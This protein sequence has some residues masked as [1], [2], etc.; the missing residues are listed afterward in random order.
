MRAP[1]Y[2]PDIDGI[3]AIAVVLVI[4]FHAG[5]APVSGGYIGVDVFFVIS[6]YL[7]TKLLLAPAERRLL[8]NLAEFY[9]RR[10]RRIVPALVAVLLVATS[11]AI[12]LLM[13]SDLV[14][15]GRF[16]LSVPFFVSNLEA[17]HETGYF[18]SGAPENP[19]LHLWSISVEEQFYLL[20]P[21]LLLALA[22]RGRRQ[23][24]SLL[25]CAAVISFV[26]CCWGSYAKPSATYYLIPPRAWE[27]LL[28]GLGAVGAIRAP[29]SK[30]SAE[31]ISAVALVAISVAA[32]TYSL[33]TPYPGIYAAV[34]TAST[35]AL[36]VVGATHSTWTHK[37][38]S[39]RPLVA[40][41]LISYSL[42]LWHLPI[43][44]FYRYFYL[45]QF[46]PVE[47]AVVL[48]GT[49]LLSAVTWYV[50]EQP[51]RRR[52]IF[53]SRR[54]VVWSALL[55]NCVIALLGLMFLGTNGLPERFSAQ[56]LAIASG[57][58][59]RDK[60][61]DKCM[62]LPYNE[63][64]AGNLCRYGSIGGARIMVWG[65]S[66]AAALLPAYRVLARRHGA[67]LYFAAESA[68]RPLLHIV[69]IDAPRW[70]QESCVR[71]NDA[72]VKAVQAIDPNVV[73]LSGHWIDSEDALRS[74][75]GAVESMH[76][77]HFM[78]GLEQTIAAID[79]DK[80]AVCI[81][82][83]VPDLKY[84][85]PQALVMAE[86]RNVPNDF[87]R[88]SRQ[89]A[90]NEYRDVDLDIRRLAG[91]YPIRIADPRDSL[92]AQAMCEVEFEG[93]ALYRDS[94]HLSVAGAEFAMES[95]EPCFKGQK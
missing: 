52:V 93:R 53:S 60:D 79:P 74:T 3:R 2:R 34:P 39:T 80:R 5:I 56:V 11:V 7:I 14:R 30:Y 26:L 58:A 33:H 37:V 38:L 27:L 78:T 49:Y 16:L 24:T 20:Y 82:L 64:A 22:R 61:T 57:A 50:V 92:C 67:E 69:N 90:I 54:Q 10:I 31:I 77:S 88:V 23:I 45:K 83:G 55:A 68:C 44:A 19:L 65:D 75:S 40:T 51:V 32:C 36:L 81:V 46:R 66:H 62:S 6:G 21:I 28:G 59:D 89:A 35:V 84:S 17:W 70:K 94:E 95:L 76:G 85:L 71:F 15:F 42:Y 18:Q 1:E 47:L 8:A 43:L 73:I 4:L 48:A 29:K 41:G 86:R 13:P 12:W 25:I 63:V 91:R 87:L 72:M 9:T